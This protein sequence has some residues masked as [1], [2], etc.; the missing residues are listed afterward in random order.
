MTSSRLLRNWT[1]AFLLILPVTVAAAGSCPA[2]ESMRP[3]LNSER[4]RAC[5]GSYGVEVLCQSGDLRVSSLY[6]TGSAGERVTR[7]L[8]V[9]RFRKEVPAELGSTMGKIRKGASIGA[10]LK[11]EGW[12]VEKY[13][14][15]MG[16]IQIPEDFRRMTGLNEDGGTVDSL[17]A[18]FIY[19]LSAHKDGAG[20]DIAIITEMYDPRYLTLSDLEAIYDASATQPDAASQEWLELLDDPTADCRE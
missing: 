5:F 15:F 16:A 12:G 20:V 7:T 10:T 19:G 3:L 2:T 4:I 13:P 17:A 14:R 9:T 8:A 11:E 1:V 18:V 6:S